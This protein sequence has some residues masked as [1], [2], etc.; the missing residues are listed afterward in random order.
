MKFAESSILRLLLLLVCRHKVTSFS[1]SRP[2][3]RAAGSCSA[4]SSPSAVL[5]QEEEARES[6]TSSSS[7]PAPFLEWIA[8][9][10]DEVTE[11]RE[12]VVEGE[13]PSYLKGSLVRNGGGV[14][15]APGD[16]SSPS[17]LHIFDGLA[18]VSAWRINGESSS[19][20]YR[21]QFIQ[22]KMYQ[23]TMRQH[24]LP[25][26]IT[27][28]PSSSSVTTGTSSSGSIGMWELVQ[29]VINSPGMDNAP[30]NIWD[31]DP[32]NTTNDNDKNDD[33]DSSSTP[34]KKKRIT[35]R[36]DSPAR[37]DLSLEDLSTQSTF[38]TLGP[39]VDH[40]NGV[41]VL[42]TAHPLYG[43][44]SS[45]SDTTNNNH[46]Q[47]VATYNVA[48]VVT[49]PRGLEIAVIRELPNGTRTAVASH[50]AQQGNVP[51]IHSFGITDRYVIAILQPLRLNLLDLSTTLQQGFL[52]AMQ[53]VAQTEV[54]V[55][56]L[57]EERLVFHECTNEKVF[58][59]HSVSSTTTA[60][61]YHGDDDRQVCVRLCAYRTADMITGEHHFLRMDQARQGAE[62]RNQIPKGGVFCDITAH[63]DTKSLTVE[64]MDQQEIEQG[65]ELPTTRYSRT[66]RKEQSFMIGNG[67]HPRYVY[68][69]GAYANGSSNYDDWGIYKFDLQQRKVAA[70]F[71]RPLHF[72]SEP[73]F[74]PN[75]A[76]TS[77]D[78]GVVLV[79]M[80][81]GT[82]KETGLFVLDG[83]SLHVLATVWTQ[84]HRS[85]MDFHGGW[86]PNKTNQ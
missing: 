37:A 35:A 68:A 80:Y 36:T 48:T 18:K 53:E 74:V 14:W 85:P 15:S 7:G 43:M 76:G 78:D 16:D 40:W 62:F 11:W 69:Y 61:R 79:Q 32:E 45:S 17:Y 71:V 46:H 82:K 73:I 75:P 6:S 84:G 27:A 1:V 65:F 60:D 64:W 41:V 44:I 12:L 56:D 51:Y 66:Y 52:R 10:T 47:D 33:D 50:P 21:N 25:V 8:D 9:A 55:F 58:F 70:R 29:A 77:E 59:Y 30:V 26:T 24:K 54:M 42:E 34:P 5:E 86:I 4:S 23:T 22:S 57:Q 63:L 28:G 67:Q 19:V 83:R 72:P 39:P 2:P 3:I 20:Q 31:Y 49:I 13:I 81:D 38:G